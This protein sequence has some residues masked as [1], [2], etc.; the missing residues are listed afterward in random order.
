M[1]NGKLVN[2]NYYLI[3]APAGS[4]KTTFITNKIKKL[5]IEDQDV[6][7][8]CITF[9]NRAVDELK[10][11][12][13]STRVFVGTIHSFL[14]YF[15]GPFFKNDN[16][17][18]LYF[19]IYGDAIKDRIKNTEQKGLISESNKR[20]EEKHGQLDFKTVK[21]N[22]KELY[23]NESEYNF[24]YRGGL[25][26]DDL[27]SFSKTVFESFNKISIKI[28]DKF[29]YVFIDEYQ[30]TMTEVLEILYYSL[31][32]SDTKLFLF[33][34]RMQQ[35]YDNYDGSFEEKFKRFNKDKKLSI[36]YRSNEKI[37]NILNNLY[38]DNFYEQEP[39]EE[40][41]EKYKE[42]YHPRFIIS[43]DLRQDIDVCIESNKEYL[44]LYLSNWARFEEIEAI[45]LYNIFNKVEKYKYGNRYSV[46][47]VLTM[48]YK[49]NPDSLI[50]LAY[51]TNS[52]YEDYYEN[53]QGV[54]IQKLKKYDS[55][56]S[57]KL[58][59]IIE[60]DNK[61]ILNGQLV[62][63]FEEIKEKEGT[64]GQFISKYKESNLLNEDFLEVIIAEEY[65]QVHTVELKELINVY[66]YIENPN[67]STQ[68]GVKGES[69]DTVIFVADDG[70]TPNV[71]MY[72]FFDMFSKMEFSLT[73]LL[74]FYYPF[75]DEIN[76]LEKCIGMKI[77]D[78]KSKEHKENKKLI[79]A[80]ID[81]VYNR[82]KDNK[83]F[84]YLYESEY[85]KY[86]NGTGVTNMRNFLKISKIEGVL[87]AYRLFY[88]GC[89]RARRNLTVIINKTKLEKKDID[90]DS[91]SEKLTRIGFEQFPKEAKSKK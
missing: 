26:H 72:D 75:K 61:A 34:D 35:I 23:Y 87:N 83:Y 29:Q 39:Y 66:E 52:M 16:V 89:S 53:K 6:Y 8:L 38:N 24:L 59:P 15:M 32:D 51:L 67:V 3:N 85:K 31:K 90:I 9:T 28:K 46:A 25:S 55:I 12:I 10:S 81:K 19:E 64:I 86:K 70:N 69:H 82:Y 13:D 58:N 91:L 4:G 41:E 79:S 42:D 30:D 50:K 49:E 18:D 62:S 11:K 22:V 80:T 71:K 27:I 47:Q 77:K 40:N 14:N 20:F 78:I 33:G 74:E 7:I 1:V 65:S 2:N 56:F 76:K 63:I 21:Q 17:I 68:H 5:L 44:I 73:S 45:N 84:K 57:Y 36:N 88:V 43:K 48:P 54:I 37:I 60:H